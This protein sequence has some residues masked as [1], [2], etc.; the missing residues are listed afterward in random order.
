[1]ITSHSPAPSER[2]KENVSGFSMKMTVF[3]S[4]FVPVAVKILFH[5]SIKVLVFP[6]SSSNEAL[7]SCPICTELLLLIIN[8]VVS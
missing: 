7:P 2:F 3:E 4:V 5:E 1:M 8:L 6:L